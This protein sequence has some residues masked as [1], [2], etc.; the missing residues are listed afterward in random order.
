VGLGDDEYFV[1]SDVSAI[2]AHTRQVVYLDD[3][4]MAVLDRQGYR[5]IDLQ[6]TE[7]Q[8]KVSRIDW[9][10]AQIERGGF[11]HFMLKEI[12]EQPQ[13]VENTMRGRLLTDDGT[14]KLGGLNLTDEELLSFTNIVITACGTS[15]HSALIGEGMLEELARIPVEVE[16][17]SEFRYRNPIVDERTLCIVISA[18]ERQCAGKQR[19]GRAPW[20]RQRGRVDHRA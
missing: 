13:T 2:L 16:Y 10:L 14:S 9:D 15:W 8:K 4:E 18:G 20:H 11:A 19:R 3:G 12:F 17:A 1:A 6:A 5:I 7:I